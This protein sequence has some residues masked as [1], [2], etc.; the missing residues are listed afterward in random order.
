MPNHTIDKSPGL[1][2][3]NS[4]P[5]LQ[6][7]HH[8]SALLYANGGGPTTA[9]SHHQSLTSSSSG[10]SGS[11]SP[12]TAVSS[13]NQNTNTVSN[14]SNT[15]IISTNQVPNSAPSTV[16]VTSTGRYVC[17]Y[18]QMNCSKPSVLEKHIRRHTNERPFKC[19]LCGI[20]FKTKSNLYKHR[21]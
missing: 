3:V 13:A 2:Y 19:V 9:R 18:C 17:P 5:A 10:S 16:N 15:S 21:R 8:S 1:Q 20:A 11:P 6:Q 4:Y 12:P 14:N 7:H